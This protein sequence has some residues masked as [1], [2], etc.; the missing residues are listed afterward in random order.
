MSGAI[1]IREQ[2]ENMIAPEAKKLLGTKEAADSFTRVVLTAFNKSPSLMKCSHMSLMAAIMDLCALRLMPNT[3]Q[4][5]AYL[6]PRRVDDTLICN[7]EIGY[8]GYCELAYRGGMVADIDGNVIRDGDFIEYREG[9]EGFVHF[10]RQLGKGRSARELMGCYIVVAMKS[11]VNHVKVLDADQLE[12]FRKAMLRQN[13]NKATPAWTFFED[14]M[15]LKS[16]LKRVGKLLPLGDYVQ[17][18]IEI[19][20]R[21][22]ELLPQSVDRPK[23]QLADENEIRTIKNKESESKPDQGEPAPDA[24]IGSGGEKK[25]E[26]GEFVF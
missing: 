21:N 14:E 15:Y 19:E 4:G 1:A 12:G 8:R 6:I 10:K 5:H 7:V 16:A 3:M 23:L 2:W 17:K 24:S 18:A 13:K 22:V 25:N 9:T 11:G 20:Q 26:K